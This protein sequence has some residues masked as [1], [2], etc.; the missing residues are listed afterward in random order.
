MQLGQHT[1]SLLITVPAVL[2]TV[3]LL[4]NFMNNESAK[5]G[6]DN[7]T[8]Q[9][10]Q[11]EEVNQVKDFNSLEINTIKEGEGEGAKDGDGLVV[12]Y[13]LSLIDTGI[14]QSS[15]EIDR[16]FDFVLG[17]G[18]VIPGWEQGVM[19]MKVG[20]IRELKIPSSMGYGEFGSGEIPGNAGLIF[21]VELLEIL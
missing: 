21:K 4:L 10:S 18:Q 16:P 15:Y 5:K 2:V 1:K 12:H 6:I 19:G 14:L 3:F 8:Q 11:R 9:E 17:Q 13:E 7:Q 20:E